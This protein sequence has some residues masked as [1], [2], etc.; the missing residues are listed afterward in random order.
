VVVV[1]QNFSN[2]PDVLV[3]VVTFSLLALVIVAPIASIFG[4]RK[5]SY[6]IY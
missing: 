6:T 2:E 3:M 5:A 1:M 4:R